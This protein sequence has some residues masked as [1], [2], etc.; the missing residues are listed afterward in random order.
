[1]NI[2][3]YTM[4]LASNSFSF[5][6]SLR[7]DSNW[8]ICCYYLLLLGHILIKSY[9]LSSLSMVVLCGTDCCVDITV[10]VYGVDSS[11]SIL[12]EVDILYNTLPTI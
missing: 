8:K 7:H 4:V 2:K 12:G 11:G 5:G 9:T 3:P 6:F 1:M 10:L